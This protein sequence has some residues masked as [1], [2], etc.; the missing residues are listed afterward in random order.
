[1]AIT[2]SPPPSGFVLLSSKTAATSSTIDFTGLDNAYAAYVIK[3]TSAKVS[4]DD[5]AVW[6]RVGTGATPT[7]QTTGYE[8]AS[9]R[10]NLGGGTTLTGSATSAVF[11]TTAT[12]TNGAVGNGAGKSF[13]AAIEFQNPASADYMPISFCSRHVRAADAIMNGYNGSGQYSTAGAITA[14]RIMPDAGN[15]VSGGFALYGYLR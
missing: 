2:V 13:S 14:L 5:A 3:I 12:G 4:A 10:I 1:M 6:L 9:T 7:Y 11:L 8:Y 15:F